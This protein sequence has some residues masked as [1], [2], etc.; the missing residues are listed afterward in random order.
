MKLFLAISVLINSVLV[1]AVLGV[2]PVIL[3]ISILLNIGAGWFIYKLMKDNMSM[4]ADMEGLLETVYSLEDHIRQIHDLEMFY[5][6]TTLQG[7]IDHTREVVDEIDFYR[8]KYSLEDPVPEEEE[9]GEFLG[10]E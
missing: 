8:Q 1:M 5:G 6:D 9:E 10:E 2:V 3:F 4:D 7:L